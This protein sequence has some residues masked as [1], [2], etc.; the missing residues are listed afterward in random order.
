MKKTKKIHQNA[1]HQNADKKRG[2]RF[3]KAKDMNEEEKQVAPEAAAEEPAQEQEAQTPE[4]SCAS[5]PGKQHPLSSHR[6]T[7]F[8]PFWTAV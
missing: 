1:K 8:A 6:V 4:T 5:S 7:D 2:F 3:G